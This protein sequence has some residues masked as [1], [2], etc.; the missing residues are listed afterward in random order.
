MTQK[1]GIFDHVQLGVLNVRVCVAEPAFVEKQRCQPEMDPKL[2][3][4]PA[5]RGRDPESCLVV[6]DGLLCLV[7]VGVYLTE[8][9]MALA[10]LKL[11]AFVWEG[12]ERSGNSLKASAAPS[13]S[14]SYNNDA[15]RRQESAWLDLL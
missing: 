11:I 4:G 15:S 2:F 3:V 1:V 6:V 9:A 14:S 7:L 13:W 10:D 8:E 12:T 5:E